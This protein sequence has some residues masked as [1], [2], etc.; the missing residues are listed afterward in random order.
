MSTLTATTPKLGN[1]IRL[2][3]LDNGWSQT[4]LGHE[5]GVAQS[6]ISAWENS[7]ARPSIAHLLRLADALDA[8]LKAFLDAVAIEETRL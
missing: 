7:K 6:I 2:A 1:L 8:D 3:R 5:V 4:M